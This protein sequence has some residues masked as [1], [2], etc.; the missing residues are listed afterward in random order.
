[1][2]PL[3]PSGGHR[4]PS[5][6]LPQGT[7]PGQREVT[8][9][10]LPPRHCLS[11]ALESPPVPWRAPPCPGPTLRPCPARTGDTGQGTGPAP[12]TPLLF[13]WMWGCTWLCTDALGMARPSLS[14]VT[15]VLS[16]V[17]GHGG[18]GGVQGTGQGVREGKAGARRGLLPRVPTSRRHRAEPCGD[19]PVPGR[20]G[21][22][23]VPARA[24]SAPAPAQRGCSGGD[25]LPRGAAEGAGLQKGLG[26]MRENRCDRVTRGG[27][28]SGR[29]RPDPPS[30]CAKLEEA[31]EQINNDN[32]K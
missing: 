16:R 29:R 11:P 5:T 19:S 18:F 12:G 6:R 1:M 9:T 13:S 26:E 4:A 28:R 17:P 32:K 20:A 7:D 30:A 25:P 21:S 24:E 14:L 8:V 15:G 31:G 27:A 10:A 2:S 22:T 3:H 23:Q